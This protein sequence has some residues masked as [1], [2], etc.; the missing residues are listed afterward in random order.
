MKPLLY[1]PGDLV[2]IRSD[3]KAD[4][5]YPVWYGPSAGQRTLYC[6]GDMVKHGGEY[7]EIEEYD[8]DDDFYTLKDV[9]WCW[10]ESMFEEPKECVCSSLL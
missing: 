9:A 7:H 5:D 6:N 3:L 4:H 8:D 2:K 10:T 1:K